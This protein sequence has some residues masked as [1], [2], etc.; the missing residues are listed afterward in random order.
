MD[1]DKLDYL[2]RYLQELRQLSNIAGVTDSIRI[3]MEIIDKEL[4]K[5]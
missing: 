1:Y 2:L 3:T 4:M 5:K